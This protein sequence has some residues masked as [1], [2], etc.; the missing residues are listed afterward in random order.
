[1]VQIILKGL[2]NDLHNINIDNES[3]V[4]ELKCK[5]SSLVGVPCNCLSLMSQGGVNHLENDKII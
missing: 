3:K 4:N 2:E 5:V 1:M